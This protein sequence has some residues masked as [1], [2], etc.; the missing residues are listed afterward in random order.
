[1]EEPWAAH[2]VYKQHTG[3]PGTPG[4]QAG[5]GQCQLAGA[6]SLL[7]PHCWLQPWGSHFQHHCRAEL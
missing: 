2:T 3:C 6:G 7:S 5:P 1:M 4:H